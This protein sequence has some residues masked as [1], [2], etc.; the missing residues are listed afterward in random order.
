MK[1]RKLTP[2]E[3]KDMVAKMRATNRINRSHYRLHRLEDGI[4]YLIDDEL[5]GY[6]SVTNDIENV[7]KEVGARHGF[8]HRIVYK[9][10]LGRWDEAIHDGKGKF[11]TFA[12]FVLQPAI[13]G[14]GEIIDR[15]SNIEEARES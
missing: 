6:V 4:I 12:P 5:P 11:L 2:G 3:R 8:Q 9:D 13:H 7:V 1:N 14:A 15:P 10:T